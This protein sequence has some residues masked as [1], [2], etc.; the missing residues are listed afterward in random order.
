[1][2]GMGKTIPIALDMMARKVVLGADARLRIIAERNLGQYAARTGELADLFS[3]VGL[4]AENIKDK[5]EEAT[6][7]G[8]REAL[9]AELTTLFDSPDVVVVADS[10]TIQHLTN[11]WEK[12]PELKIAMLTPHSATIDE[13]HETIQSKVAA[14]VS[15]NSRAFDSVKHSDDKKLKDESDPVWK[16]VSSLTDSQIKVY[17][18]RNEF[19]KAKNNES[20][21]LLD[22]DNNRVMISFKAADVIVEAAK[23]IGVKLRLNID[24]EHN[25]I[26]GEDSHLV[27]RA[28]L[29][30]GHRTMSDAKAGEKYDGVFYGIDSGNTI[31]PMGEDGLL[32]VNSVMSDTYLQYF[33]LMKERTV[34]PALN[35]SAI[36][37]GETTY[38]ASTVIAL[39]GRYAS[40]K[41]TS[42]STEVMGQMTEGRTG[43]SIENLTAGD[44]HT[45]IMSKITRGTM[46]NLKAAILTRGECAPA[47][48]ILGWI[49]DVKRDD[50]RE[51]VLFG[52]KTL[53]REIA[54]EVERELT[55]KGYRVHIIDSRPGI[56]PTALARDAEAGDIFLVTSAGMTGLNYGE[57][58][59]D[60]FVKNNGTG[61]RFHATM[62]IGNADLLRADIFTQFLGRIGRYGETTHYRLDIDFG[63]MT[64]RLADFRDSADSLREFGRIMKNAGLGHLATISE[65]I[66]RT[67][68]ST[69][70][71][72]LDK[73]VGEKDPAGKHL[74]E[75]EDPD[76]LMHAI[77]L[78]SYLNLADS[79]SKSDQHNI[80]DTFKTTGAVNL[81]RNIIEARDTT[82]ESRETAR[83]K[84]KE[85]L[86]FRKPDVNLA[87][88]DMST[89]TEGTGALFFEKA[90]SDMIRDT[91]AVIDYLNAHIDAQADP[92]AAGMVRL[93]ELKLDQVASGRRD[94]T[95]PADFHA[96]VPFATSDM[97]LGRTDGFVGIFSIL[98]RFSTDMMPDHNIDS[99]PARNP[100][101]ALADTARSQL[102]ELG[103]ERADKISNAELVNNLVR[104]LS[105][106]D[107]EGR[108]QAWGGF[109]RGLMLPAQQHDVMTSEL[110]SPDTS[111]VALPTAIQPAQLNQAD[112]FT[113]AA[114]SA[115]DMII[116]TAGASQPVRVA[117]IT[118]A[119]DKYGVNMNEDEKKKLLG[120]LVFACDPRFSGLVGQAAA[121]IVASGNYG[122]MTLDGLSFRLTTLDGL[123][124]MGGIS[125]QMRGGIAELTKAQATLNR[126]A[127]QRNAYPNSRISGLLYK[128]AEARLSNAY[129]K[130][131]QAV[132]SMALA[133]TKQMPNVTH[134]QALAIT[135]LPLRCVNANVESLSR[136]TA[137]LG[138]ALG[139]A[140]AELA[141]D[142][143]GR[144]DMPVLQNMAFKKEKPEDPFAGNPQLAQLAAGNPQL[145]E[146]FNKERDVARTDQE[147]DIAIGQF[148]LTG[149]IDEKVPKTYAARFKLV[150]RLVSELARPGRGMTALAQRLNIF[151]LTDVTHIA[152]TQREV[153]RRREFL[154]SVM[155]D[156]DNLGAATAQ[157]VMPVLDRALGNDL[158]PM[159]GVTRETIA[160]FVTGH[161]VT[162]QD[163]NRIEDNAHLTNAEERE[164]NFAANNNQPLFRDLPFAEAVSVARILNRC[165]DPQDALYGGQGLD[166]NLGRLLAEARKDS[167]SDNGVVLLVFIL[168]GRANKDEAAKIVA[169][170]DNFAEASSMCAAQLTLGQARNIVVSPIPGRGLR[171]FIRS[172]VRIPGESAQVIATRVA[173]AV[174]VRSIPPV[175]G[176]SH[177]GATAAYDLMA[178]AVEGVARQLGLDLAS[179]PVE[180]LAH[181]ARVTAFISNP[182]G[183]TNAI[184]AQIL[185][186]LSERAFEGGNRDRGFALRGGTRKLSAPTADAISAKRTE[187]AQHI[188]AANE[189]ID[190]GNLYG[191]AR[192]L[193]QAVGLNPRLT[194]NRDAFETLGRAVTRFSAASDVL[195]TRLARVIGQARGID[196]E[197]QAGLILQLL[198]IIINAGD[199][200]RDQGRLTKALA[201][202]T[203]IPANATLASVKLAFA[204]G[205]AV[206]MSPAELN[207][208]QGNT[209]AVAGLMHL[210]N[211]GLA[212]AVQTMADTARQRQARED[213]AAFL[214][215][216]S[217]ALKDSAR[218][219]QVVKDAVIISAACAGA[220]HTVVFAAMKELG[221]KG[222][223]HIEAL[224]PADRQ[225][226]LD[227]IVS[228]TGSVANP[229]GAFNKIAILAVLSASANLHL[230]THQT[231]ELLNVVDPKAVETITANLPSDMKKKDKDALMA[232]IAGNLLPRVTA[233]GRAIRANPEALTSGAIKAA[234][235]ITFSERRSTRERASGFNAL[236]AMLPL[237]ENTQAALKAL[238]NR[239]KAQ[240]LGEVA[241]AARSGNLFTANGKFDAKAAE[242]ILRANEV[243]INFET[244]LGLLKLV[245]PLLETALKDLDKAAQGAFVSG[246]MAVM[247]AQ[248]VNIR[249][250][251]ISG[252]KDRAVAVKQTCATVA[253]TSSMPFGQALAVAV[254]LGVAPAALPGLVSSM[255]RAERG[256]FENEITTACSALGFVS[257]VATGAAD[258]LGNMLVNKFLDNFS[259]N[260]E[261]TVSAI[262][263]ADTALAGE[264]NNLPAL[265]KD[266]V[267]AAVMNAL[268]G[269]P[270][271]DRLSKIESEDAVKKN[272]RVQKTLANIKAR[273]FV[274]EMERASANEQIT[275]VGEVRSALR[276]A[277]ARRREIRSRIGYLNSI[278]PAMDSFA[279]LGVEDML[280][281]AR[282]ELNAPK[283]PPRDEFLVSLVRTSPE[284]LTSIINCALQTSKKI[285]GK[286]AAA[287]LRLLD[288]ARSLTM[289]AIEGFGIDMVVRQRAA[290]AELYGS[291]D[292]LTIEVMVAANRAADEIMAFVA[293]RLVENRNYTDNRNLDNAI[294]EIAAANKDKP[295]IAGALVDALI[296]RN[297]LGINIREYDALRGLN[298]RGL[299]TDKAVVA[300]VKGIA[301]RALEFK[302]A[303][304]FEQGGVAAAMEYIEN[305][306]TT[307]NIVSE[308]APQLVIK[309][310]EL[311]KAEI[312]DNPDL[313]ITYCG[314]VLPL[315]KQIYEEA[316]RANNES[317]RDEAGRVI[318]LAYDKQIGALTLMGRLQDDAAGQ[319]VIGFVDQEI[320]WIRT[321]FGV[322]MIIDATLPLAASLNNA[323]Q[324]LREGLDVDGA[325]L[326]HNKAQ[327]ML[328]EF[329][330]RVV[331]GVDR[332]NV[333]ERQS[334]LINDV[335]TEIARTTKARA[336]ILIL[337][338]NSSGVRGVVD[339]VL[340]ERPG[341]RRINLALATKIIEQTRALITAN[342][343][344]VP[345]ATINE[346][347]EMNIDIARRVHA[348]IR[349]EEEY[350]R[351]AEAPKPL[352][353]RSELSAAEKLLVSVHKDRLE[354]A[355]MNGPARTAL[356]LDDMTNT[357]T[358]GAVGEKALIQIAG[359]MQEVAK[360]LTVAENRENRDMGLAIFEASVNI[361]RAAY[362]DTRGPVTSV[363]H[364]PA[365]ERRARARAL[366]TDVAAALANGWAGLLAVRVECRG[367]DQ[368]EVEF[369]ARDFNASF[370]E[371]AG[372][373]ATAF[374]RIAGAKMANEP[375][376]AA[377]TQT[378]VNTLP[379]NRSTAKLNA[380]LT[381]LLSASGAPD[382][383]MA[384]E[385]HVA[386]TAA[387]TGVTERLVATLEKRPTVELTD[388][389][390]RRMAARTAP[391]AAT[392]ALFVRALRARLAQMAIGI[393][394]KR[395][396]ARHA[397]YLSET[398][399]RYPQYSAVIMALLVELGDK[400]L[401][402]GKKAGI[403]DGRRYCEAAETIFRG[404]DADTTPDIVRNAAGAQNIEAGTR[405]LRIN[406]DNCVKARRFDDAVGFINAVSMNPD[407][408]RRLMP[409][410]IEQLTKYAL[411]RRNAAILL[412]RINTAL[413]ASSRPGIAQLIR[414]ATAKVRAQQLKLALR[415]GREEDAEEL[416]KQAGVIIE[417]SVYLELAARH[418]DTAKG[419]Q[420]ALELLGKVTAR[421]NDINDAVNGFKLPENAVKGLT[422]NELSKLISSIAEA[423]KL[424][425][426][427]LT[428]AGDFTR[429][430]TEIDG[431]IS[432]YAD[433]APLGVTYR[434]GASA[435]ASRQQALERQIMSGIGLLIDNE[436][437]DGFARRFIEVKEGELAAAI[438]SGR[439]ERTIA[440]MGSMT[441]VAR[442][443]RD[444]TGLGVERIGWAAR[445]AES[446][447][448]VN[449][450]PLLISNWNSRTG[451]GWRDDENARRTEGL[452][453][454]AIGL[455]AGILVKIGDTN[456]LY[457]VLN[458]F[459]ERNRRAY[460][461]VSSDDA[462]DTV[463][464]LDAAF[465]DRGQA[466]NIAGQFIGGIFNTVLAEVE[467]NVRSGNTPL[468]TL[469]DII[470]RCVEE[471]AAKFIWEDRRSL[472]EEINRVRES[473]SEEAANNR[474][475]E[476]IDRGIGAASLG[477]D[478]AG[479]VKEVLM[480]R[481]SVRR[482][483]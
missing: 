360:R 280:D 344:K 420:R 404:V 210:V 139:R 130:Y 18:T 442:M 464:H 300:E 480:R 437:I 154:L 112:V 403:A 306:Y 236:V 27:S 455:V 8:D 313:T 195:K 190:R 423:F 352:I 446:V 99:S 359:M 255:S 93:C 76:L 222:I 182:L 67:K 68:D 228:V 391:D 469:Q 205:I 129:D 48:Q 186:R 413:A 468:G 6:N 307:P 54:D 432:L 362:V 204:A 421:A 283:L 460:V 206:N 102:R 57:R 230:S 188:A 163:L 341:A 193:E 131:Y 239:V 260:T 42:A 448:K 320:R 225:L 120:V 181:L 250:D 408:S 75:S 379:S 450:V 88:A 374:I 410:M 416:A 303:A 321:Q 269:R 51:G 395:L 251:A 216:S 290:L 161:E 20:C 61:A 3:A 286:D 134:A 234:V 208:L 55:G 296:G 185:I 17:R 217:D 451:R 390:I 80:T 71:T 191:A 101:M 95:L 365:R 1:N 24:S 412:G 242:I 347:L 170:H 212:N 63:R 425:L 221:Y 13:F 159:H 476:A 443:M 394:G 103:C 184:A 58:L 183:D 7:G 166:H 107:A 369:M 337:T 399:L 389:L 385:A 90:A 265:V 92:L 45:T 400:A 457:R 43:S 14:I 146:M 253:F 136:N 297:F 264:I 436:M 405:I 311:A 243:K 458:N 372:R 121:G 348:D 78:N 189:H 135:L 397:A 319:G 122:T 345:A 89:G 445:L 116:G 143:M 382:T 113:A 233:A 262:G 386:G 145:A 447:T 398:A 237:G 350:N 37:V 219:Q 401:A 439:E 83:A 270:Y 456:T 39:S 11:A 23:D 343:G 402:S 29:A 417:V 368:G 84:L 256:A 38:Q 104:A 441:R 100:I 324:G 232:R 477:E 66:K 371:I 5:W 125:D 415:E 258:F 463:S 141:P 449:L 254:K 438:N 318:A 452:V 346:W 105:T 156:L 25:I 207:A 277:E 279:R 174:S 261:K 220:G 157:G 118:T 309:L 203:N 9:H 59:S 259:G 291:I 162:A 140:A 418:P 316:V 16:V 392:Q 215:N 31:R 79:I 304:A 356:V 444:Q 33:I 257:F 434:L 424:R 454:E 21:M 30:W 132:P 431:L 119:V 149:K 34:N 312:S 308:F 128:R 453:N 15:E 246:G 28:L 302:L 144:V 180:R 310:F 287:A 252:R 226:A 470:T 336:E 274:R 126:R 295:E 367:I 74:T 466:R 282:A 244:Q 147:I 478:E 46:A 245:D 73:M 62:I 472:D 214:R 187:V 426:E 69:V 197:R 91:Y 272:A 172:N 353:G 281:K 171:N 241:D 110:L 41:G 266:G 106:P 176:T 459:I 35:E 331:D 168:T 378:A 198:G 64:Q 366:K 238:P 358:L 267:A 137:A 411:G 298:E 114:A 273:L 422:E 218:A 284:F 383:A 461:R 317:L 285:A 380:D 396:A 292:R 384:H 467:T 249:F 44:L 373:A 388:E 475:I 142:A 117:A 370:P 155:S 355:V 327:E 202:L 328:G 152:G 86:A 108:V 276:N 158:E 60:L 127:I 289:E 305:V 393:N 349:V 52:D 115:L 47:T 409:Y 433:L 293:A 364:P 322:N 482:I 387:E 361:L 227:A 381:D 10:V 263:M 138:A 224:E 175:S 333:T 288:A 192:E 40:M 201:S 301:R 299:I 36:S 231:L 294:L 427:I 150:T 278:L 351:E 213:F 363:K 406:F 338:D 268:L 133:L 419:R 471:Q 178:D 26:N 275:L 479:A 315:V 430:R 124:A 428:K 376:F 53:T 50:P 12:S 323:A 481:E 474:F 97:M 247:M 94:G 81:L 109:V 440:V 314:M 65:F 200:I 342:K 407:F 375:A 209:A 357:V 326:L 435:L 111:Y 240:L 167:I 153:S 169:L 199:Y 462:Y 223:E 85:I 465:E 179:A 165:Q 354:A 334:K 483:R 96:R 196:I 19:N 377:T 70:K 194:D 2:V 473:I 82:A 211:P 160:S 72:W 235:A 123:A 340:A 151:D 177:T 325:V 329:H 271:E 429:A 248:A 4:R 335:E 330:A 87:P 339:T 173:D 32:Q 56:D 49:L 229:A 414:D 332:A 164:L 22:V 148:A 77:C 98:K